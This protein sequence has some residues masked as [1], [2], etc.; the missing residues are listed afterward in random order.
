[1]L[2]CLGDSWHFNAFPLSKSLH[3]KAIIFV[4]FLS[5]IL[6]VTGVSIHYTL[7]EVLCLFYLFA[8]F[9]RCALFFMSWFT[10]HGY[11]KKS[12][13][14]K[15]NVSKFNKSRNMLPVYATVCLKSYNCINLKYQIAQK[16]DHMEKIWQ[17]FWNQR[18]KIIPKTLLNPN[19][20]EIYLK[21][22]RYLMTLL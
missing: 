15:K 19:P 17:Q 20:H 4:Y 12:L 6:L 5:N 1:M 18:P 10:N 3:S 9:L 7:T 22:L 13:L 11:Y 16:R 21:F 2:S 14:S 8:C